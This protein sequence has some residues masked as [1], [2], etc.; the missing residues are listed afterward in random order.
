[1]IFNLK[2]LPESTIF[3]RVYE[4]GDIPAKI[5]H[6]EKR[7]VRWNLRKVAGSQEESALQSLDL[8]KFFPIFFE[9]LRETQDPYRFLADAGLNDIIGLGSETILPLIPK[10]IPAAK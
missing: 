4:R 2:R 5:F 6:G 9:G 3:R 1:M 7:E 10:I 8:G